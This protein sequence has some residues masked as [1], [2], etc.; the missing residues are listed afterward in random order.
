MT[1][2]RHPDL[3]SRFGGQPLIVHCLGR[4]CSDTGLVLT[5]GVVERLPLRSSVDVRDVADQSTVLTDE[6]TLVVA[7]YEVAGS[8]FVARALVFGFVHLVL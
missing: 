1:G 4:G 8:A 2:R 5:F 3:S 6:F 7:R